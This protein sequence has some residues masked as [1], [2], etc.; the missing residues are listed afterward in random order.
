MSVLKNKS[1]ESYIAAKLLIDNKHF[2]SSVHCSYYSC[3]QLMKYILID[4][5]GKTEDDL[6]A[7]QQLNKEHSHEYLINYF[8]KLL[9]QNG[10]YKTYRNSIG[11][12]PKLKVL[13]VKADYKAINIIEEEAIQAHSLSKKITT[14][15]RHING[16]R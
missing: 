11:E 7:E 12:L 14:D 8:I 5:E 1:D 15:L 16:I 2:S 6:L 10:V 4:L 3:I 9:Q 13:R